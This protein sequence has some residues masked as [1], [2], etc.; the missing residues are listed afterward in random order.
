[1][2]VNNCLPFT[3]LKV[4][5]TN[6]ECSFTCGP[7]NEKRG[8]I[9]GALIQNLKNKAPVRTSQMLKFNFL[10]CE[11]M[12]NT[13]FLISQLLSYKGVQWEMSF[14]GGCPKAAIHDDENQPQDVKR[15]A[16]ELQTPTLIMLPTFN[17]TIAVPLP[18]HIYMY[19]PTR[20][21]RSS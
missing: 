10:I 2:Q 19:C 20:N 4:S 9:L 17:D 11:S 13:N 8:L 12:Q 18:L 16:R 1:M 21:S 15:K 14:S 5:Y 6:S 3:L 7:G